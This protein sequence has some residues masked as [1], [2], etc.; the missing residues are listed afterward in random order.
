MERLRD[1]LHQDAIILRSAELITEMRDIT[2]DGDTIEAEGHG[3]DDR[4]YTCA[5]A[6][7]G[8]EEKLRRGLISRNATKQASTAAK[9]LSMS[10]QAALFNQFHLEAFFKSKSNSRMMARAAEARFRRGY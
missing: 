1:Y 2:R 6:V 5:M 9:R 3:K 7:R 10:D 4:T 8:Y